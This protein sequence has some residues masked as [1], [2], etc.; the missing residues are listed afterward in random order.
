MDRTIA[1]IMHAK[2]SEITLAGLWEYQDHEPLNNNPYKPG[3]DAYFAWNNGWLYGYD[4]E[5]DKF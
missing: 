4:M 5:I 2:I 1:K 3:S